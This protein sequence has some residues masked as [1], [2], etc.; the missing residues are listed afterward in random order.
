MS[1]AWL[2]LLLGVV[3]GSLAVLAG[4]WVARRQK[5]K[6]AQPRAIEHIDLDPE[7]A[8]AIDP[9]DPPHYMHYK[10]RSG[11]SSMHCTCHGDPI[12]VGEKVLLWPIP[13]HPEHGMDVLCART[14]GQV[15]Q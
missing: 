13:G 11:V 10:P 2:T 12:A 1:S 8:R 6:T 14:Y 7:E 5:P 3:L 9:D 15:S 4:F